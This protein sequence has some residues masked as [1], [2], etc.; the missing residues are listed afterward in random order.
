MPRSAGKDTSY[1]KKT[2]Q[3]VKKG[4]TSGPYGNDPS[5]RSVNKN[6]RPLNV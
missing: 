1:A 3:Y 5:T 2:G 6:P 4:Q